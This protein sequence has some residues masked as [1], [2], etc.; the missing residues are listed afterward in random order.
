MDEVKPL[1]CGLY[2]HYK[3]AHYEVLGRAQ[4]SETEEWLV[5]YRALYGSF[6]LW[7]R[8]QSMFE[9]QV[10]VEG[11]L[12]ARFRLLEERPSTIS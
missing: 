6:G 11:K 9:E 4:H 12:V 3:G 8:P 7:A 1:A 5:I 2:E 10:K